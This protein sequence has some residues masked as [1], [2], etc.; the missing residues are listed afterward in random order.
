MQ[1]S[2]SLG[3]GRNSLKLRIV[4]FTSTSSFLT[5]V[6]KHSGAIKT[7]Q[8]NNFRRELLA[9]A[10]TKGELYIT[11]LNNP[12]NAFRLGS[13]AA[14]ADD[15]DAMDWNKKV[16]HIMATGSSAGFATVWD[17][18]A[19]KESLT[20]NNLGRKAISAVAWDPDEPT[21]LA[22][23]VPNDQDPLILVWDLRNSNAPKKTLRA[24]EQGVLSL[25]WCLHDSELLLSCGKDNRTLCWN[26]RTEKLLGEFPIVTNWTFETR[27]CPQ[28]PNLMATASFD[29]KI[30]VHTI[31]N[32]KSDM[33][34]ST[35]SVSQSVD[36]EDFFSK[37][38]IQPQGAAFSLPK[39]PKWLARP[40]NVSIGF[41]GKLVHVRSEKNST[42]DAAMKSTI[43]ISMFS[44]DS[45][46]GEA[47]EKFEESLNNENF[48]GICN[49]KIS[50]AKTSEEKAD[51]T[52]IQT[53]IS[54]NPRQQL[55]EYLG[56]KNDKSTSENP[57]KDTT[58]DISQA[59]GTTSKDPSSFFDDNGSGEN[60]LSD[61]ASTK[62]AKT[63]NP[64]KIY[65]GTE[66][67]ADK[68]ITRAL[69]LGSFDKALD[70][71]L[72]ENRLSD[73]FMIAICGGAKCIEKVQSA[74]F[75]K[76]SEGPNYLRLLASIVGK[77]LWDV[78]YNADLADWKDVMAT[79]CTFADENKFSDLCEALGDRLEESIPEHDDDH[80]VRKDASFC[81]LAGSKLEKIVLNWVQELEEM[82]R[83]GLQ[84][85]EDDTSF[86]LH[87]KAL[88]NFIEKVTIFRRITKFKDSGLE[89][90]SETWKLAPLYSKY[91]EY[92]D[93]LA[94]HGQLRIAQ[95][96]LDLL[97]AQYSDANLA[98]SRIQHALRKA[99]AG[100]MNQK[101]SVTART[102]QRTQ[103][104]M[105]TFQPSQPTTAPN[106]APN[107][108]PYAPAG[109]N[110][111]LQP[112]GSYGYGAP[113]YQPPGQS[114]PQPSMLPQPPQIGSGFQQSVTPSS[115]SQPINPP[116]PPRAGNVGN[117]NDLPD[118]K[119]K[120][121]SRRGTPNPNTVSSPFPNQPSYSQP[122]PMGGYGNPGLHHQPNQPH[123]YTAPPVA[124]PPK[125][126]PRVT[127]PPSSQGMSGQQQQQQQSP[128]QEYE[129]RRPSAAAT[130]YAPPQPS[131][132]PNISPIAHVPRGQSPYNPPP[133]SAPPPSRY[134]PTPN[135]QNGPSVGGFGGP[136]MGGVRN[137][138]PP[139]PNPY[140]P[141]SNTFSQ[142]DPNF[143]HGPPPGP[144]MGPPMGQL[145][146]IGSRPSTAQSQRK[147]TPP[148]SKF[149]RSHECCTLEE[150]IANV[151]YS[152]WRSIAHPT[153]LT[154]NLSKSSSGYAAY[155]GTGAAVIQAASAGYREETKCFIRSSEQ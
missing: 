11:D 23:A 46:V 41:G 151:I 51:W 20:L 152:S 32:T 61:L 148:A 14:R 17:L 86:S 116:P 6:S 76:K 123:T 38:Q 102:T 5:R 64:F 27:W 44:V 15:F 30:S 104:V 126:P 62:G 121:N 80:K 117:W 87:A 129:Q 147:A 119:G 37:A 35:P 120:P 58:N 74:Y 25:S 107:P 10:G 88:Q 122:A 136:P 127:S 83:A 54:E 1:I 125:G 50:E 144:S 108:S 7:L 154:I 95:Q 12:P 155:Q 48:V 94:A 56:F 91:T 53:L 99:S 79:L 153:K 75:S 130:A 29:G 118:M 47:T 60:F 114:F 100:Q 149:R 19:K 141:H 139:P 26:P 49:Q 2:L 145:G 8:F 21:T 55:V 90:S 131:S 134:A 106:T 109:T 73:A 103:P 92:A 4:V 71:C 113:G 138:A 36:G 52:V 9:S 124:P 78:V 13:S 110:I 69:M 66:S 67:D 33:D 24:H 140:A 39:A 45:A 16:P 3:Q 128:S 68:S 133:S 93:I 115:S 101:Q 77:N 82:E 65:T 96:Y 57:A 72:K 89:Q 105:T 84:E 150:V 85:T 40:T 97:P 42:K 132:Q 43:S 18:K 81:Y 142:S 31:Q 70:V 59:N 28:N 143:G 135:T 22:T 137:P 63:N 112:P 146:Q 111:P 34:L 98:R